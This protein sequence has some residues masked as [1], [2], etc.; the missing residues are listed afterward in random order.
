MIDILFKIFTD[1]AVRPFAIGLLLILVLGAI[2]AYLTHERRIA[3]KK[4]IEERQENERLQKQNEGLQILANAANQAVEI[5]KEKETANAQAQNSNISNLN[6]ANSVL[7]DSSNFNGNGF[8]QFC[9]N[10]PLDSTCIQK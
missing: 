8:D 7:R 3:E 6:F 9:R 5:T 1:K 2:F 10:F 4:A